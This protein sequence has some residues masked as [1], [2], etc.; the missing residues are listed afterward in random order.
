MMKSDI[1]RKRAKQRDARPNQ[2]RHARDDEPVNASSGEEA[3]NR[4]AAVN[5]S[6]FEA[7]GFELSD[8]I[9]RFAGHLLDKAAFNRRE[10]E[11]TAAEYDYLLFPVGPFAESLDDLERLAADDEDIHACIEFVEAVRLMPARVQEIERVV[12]PGKE[13]VNAD[14][15]ED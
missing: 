6:V 7:A 3:L 8:D 9:G 14:S 5:V 4:D 15:A 10:I 1:A 11:R 13:A 12:G 2:Y